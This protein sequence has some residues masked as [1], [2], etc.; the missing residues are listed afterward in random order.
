[1]LLRSDDNR[2]FYSF[3][4]IMNWIILNFPVKEF[5]HASAPLV[6]CILFPYTTRIQWLLILF[7]SFS[8]CISLVLTVIEAYEKVIRVYNKT[9]EKIVI[10]EFINK[11]PFKE[12]DLTKRQEIL[13]CMLY[14]VNSKILSELK[15]NY[16]FKSTTRLIEFHDLI[17]TDKSGKLTAGCIES[18]DNVVLEAKKMQEEDCWIA[19]NTS[20]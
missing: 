10:P 13:E 5:I 15:T 17:I 1:M 11:R 6:V 7:A 8:G 12:S 16:T 4:Y 18:R 20:V 9:L 2:F 14:N 3:S 19:M